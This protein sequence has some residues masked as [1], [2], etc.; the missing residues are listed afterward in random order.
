VRKGGRSWQGG[1]SEI[2][3]GTMEA[4]VVIVPRQ[5][6]YR[7]FTATFSNNQ[8]TNKSTP[9]LQTRHSQ[10]WSLTRRITIAFA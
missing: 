2:L 9:S 10:N 6:L 3:R 1:R 7:K 4:V 8:T 5:C